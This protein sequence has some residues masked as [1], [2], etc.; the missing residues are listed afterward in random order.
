MAVPVIIALGYAVGHLGWYLGTPLGQVPVLDEHENL[1]L[2]EAITGGTLP[3][4]PFY[5]AP[6]YALLLALLRA[7]GVTA[8]GLFPAALALGAMLH[9][10]NAGLIARLARG[11]LGDRAALAAGLLAALHPVFVHYATQALDATPALM[12]FLLGLN[13]LA[14]ATSARGGAW[15]WL[16]ASGCWAA[17]ALM[18]PNY[19]LVWIALPL[20]AWMTKSTSPTSRRM[21]ASLG[22]EVLF[23]AL[24]GWQW[25]VSGAPRFLPTQGAYNFWAANRPGAHGRYYVQSL[26]LSSALAGQNPTRAE[27]LLLFS[28]ETSRD[29]ADLD[30]ANAYWSGRSRTEI[31]S[32]PA[33]WIGRL[34]QKTY[35]LVNNWEQYN[36][37][38]FAFHQ[39]RSPW[40]RWNPLCWGVLFVFGIAGAVRLRAA[41]RRAASLLGGITAIVAVSVVLFFVSARFR[42]PLAALLCVPAG[43]A[44]A[45]PI[46]IFHALT[47][48]QRGFLALGLL[49]AGLLTFSTFDGVRDTRP[50][51]QDHLLI[52]R[53]AQVVGD[54]AA[55][56]TEA[57][58][59]LALDPTR[60]NAAEFIVTSGF[61][62][63]L[64]APLSPSELAAWRVGAGRLLA[65]P[66]YAAPA[67]RVIAAMAIRDAVALRAL[68]RA[69]VPT[70]QDALGALVLL[71]AADS[72]ETARLREAALT[73]GST[74]FLMARQAIDPETFEA[75]A[76]THKPPGWSKSLA[77]ARLRIFPPLSPTR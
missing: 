25:R 57:T 7:L 5:R 52:A 41:E 1:G 73:D 23:L 34:A 51:I 12:L 71:L 4:E 74:L 39:E 30:A 77:S 63:Q 9:A 65:A 19:L 33:A 29:G 31:I 44:L 40:L 62:R 69:P 28:Q 27:S 14:T 76:H 54:D 70:N 20:L 49:G 3:A 2:A 21:L 53:A 58:A 42:L 72:A 36:N 22:G 59:A 18:R 50:F 64:L 43:A 60:S 68:A 35:A 10:L 47:P 15:A 38:T 56:W 16:G 8:G 46:A 6:G 32:R 55:T 61:N 11:W 75:W 37:K 45:H 67:A 13:F 24:A 48:A 66:D 26:S 17:A